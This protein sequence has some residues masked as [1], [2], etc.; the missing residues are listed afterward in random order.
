MVE[1]EKRNKLHLPISNILY[2]VKEI[3]SQQLGTS[4]FYIIGVKQIIISPPL[5][6][7]KKQ[8]KPIGCHKNNNKKIDL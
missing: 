2:Q 6:L 5:S 4:F 7:L 8:G 3:A 1:R